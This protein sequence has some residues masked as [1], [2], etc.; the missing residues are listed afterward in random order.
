M[1]NGNVGV[2]EGVLLDVCQMILFSL[3]YIFINNI[4]FAILEHY[5]YGLVKLMVYNMEH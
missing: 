3:N 1:I 5:W 2:L 4:M